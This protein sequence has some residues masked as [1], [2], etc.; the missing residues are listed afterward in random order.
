MNGKAQ[1]LMMNS[2]TSVSDKQLKELKIA[3]VKLNN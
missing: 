2:P 1:D 3:L